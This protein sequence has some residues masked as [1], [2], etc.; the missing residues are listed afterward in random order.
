[1]HLEP[2]APKKY[3][4]WKRSPNKMFLLYTHV[5]SILRWKRPL[6]YLAPEL[7]HSLT[8]LEKIFGEIS[9]FMFSYC[10][11]VHR[12]PHKN[13]A[14]MVV[15]IIFYEIT[16]LTRT[17]METS[18][19]AEVDHLKLI[20]QSRLRIFCSRVFN[21][22]E[23]K[24]LVL[25][26]TEGLQAAMM[27]NS[28]PELSS[29]L[30]P[31]YRGRWP[32]SDSYYHYSQVSDDATIP[33]DL[34]SC[35][36][37]R[38]DSS[39]YFY[40][41]AQTD[42]CYCGWT[43]DSTHEGFLDFFGHSATSFARYVHSGSQKIG[44]G[45]AEVL[46]DPRQAMNTVFGELCLD[47]LGL[48][49]RRYILGASMSFLLRHSILTID[50]LR[51]VLNSTEDFPADTLHDTANEFRPHLFS[52][53]LRSAITMSHDFWNFR[54]KYE[55][56]IKI[57]VVLFG[58]WAESKRFSEESKKSSEI[59]DFEKDLVLAILYLKCKEVYSDEVRR[60]RRR[61]Q[62]FAPFFTARLLASQ[63]KEA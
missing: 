15:V 12:T 42:G 41:S 26:D 50:V 33:L 36:M 61:L 4:F 6:V 31:H 9:S 58:P 57:D 63:F 27:V 23:S 60:S 17:E 24:E 37:R 18:D 7:Q 47:G 14:V 52:L 1:M 48:H 28:V 11:Q 55:H 51:E 32:K 25:G 54:R 30:P 10:D 5:H 3:L 56:D 29:C 20:L 38:S 19:P 46:F 44:F 13:A 49:E 21:F 2:E 39:E 59:F 53:I 45:K 34:P 40:D 8:I 62:H 16:H 43:F 35:L 22:D